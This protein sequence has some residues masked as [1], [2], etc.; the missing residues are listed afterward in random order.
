MKANVINKKTL[1]PLNFVIVFVLFGV[2]SSSLMRIVISVHNR[3]TDVFDGLSRDD[4]E[5]ASASGE[6]RWSLRQAVWSKD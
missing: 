3:P 1:N 5:L 2:S 4:D 6:C